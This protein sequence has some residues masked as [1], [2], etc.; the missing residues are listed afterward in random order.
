M[1]FDLSAALGAEHQKHVPG[2]SGRMNNPTSRLRVCA[3]ADMISRF[4]TKIS[5]PYGSGSNPSLCTPSSPTP[6][7]VS[8]F[9]HLTSCSSSW[10]RSSSFCFPRD[11]HFFSSPLASPAGTIYRS[12]FY[13]FAVKP[14]ELRQKSTTVQLFISASFYFTAV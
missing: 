1:N 14:V 8:S 2:L 3:S 12:Q 13:L 5:L 4:I 7:A 11:A 9:E 10:S 6:T